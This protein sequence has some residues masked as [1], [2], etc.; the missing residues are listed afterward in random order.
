M[1]PEDTH[2]FGPLFRLQQGV[3][4][5]DGRVQGGRKRRALAVHCGT[6]DGRIDDWSVGEPEM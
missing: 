5:G 4:Q 3:L 1:V 6:H 2:G